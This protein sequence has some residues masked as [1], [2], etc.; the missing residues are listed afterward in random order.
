MMIFRRTD[1]MEDKRIRETKALLKSALLHLLR[2]KDFSQ[3]SVSALCDCAGVSRTSM[4]KYYRNTTELLDDA[5]DDLIKDAMSTKPAFFACLRRH[6]RTDQ[7]SMCTLL[8]TD[9]R[10]RAVLEIDA[11]TEHFCRRIDALFQTQLKDRIAEF[12]NLSEEE[13]HILFSYQISGCI[14]AVRKSLQETDEAWQKQKE[15]IDSFLRR[16]YDLK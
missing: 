6:G 1:V 9:R 15:A 3:I 7:V 12:S 5:L 2:E 11:L 14:A 13:M 4:Y 8:R 16:A 10:F